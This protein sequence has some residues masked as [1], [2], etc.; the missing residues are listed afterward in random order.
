M[1]QLVYD[2]LQQA[3]E[4]EARAHDDFGQWQV[5]VQLLMFYAFEKQRILV[6][7]LITQQM[8]LLVF[9]DEVIGTVSRRLYAHKWH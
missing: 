9:N 8:N 1:C 2:F 7:E 3:D 4:E 5:S 6:T